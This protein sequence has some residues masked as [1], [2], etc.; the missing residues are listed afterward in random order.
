MN[1]IA[2]TGPGGTLTFATVAQQRG[3]AND[4]LPLSG[5]G[6]LTDTAAQ[7]HFRN[8]D[9]ADHPAG[10]GAVSRITCSPTETSR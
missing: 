4:L 3:N 8:R 7:R 1:A 5:A 10:E 9:R 6:A 2:V